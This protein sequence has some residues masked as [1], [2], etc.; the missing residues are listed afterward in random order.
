MH[1]QTSEAFGSLVVGKFDAEI[2]RRDVPD[3]GGII[4]AEA[5]DSAPDVGCKFAVVD[6]K[7]V[8]AAAAS[9]EVRS[10]AAVQNVGS[11]TDRN[12][13]IATA[14]MNEPVGRIGRDVQVVR[15]DIYIFVLEACCRSSICI[16]NYTYRLIGGG[17][18]R[19]D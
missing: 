12:R 4:D 16:C 8:R 19:G 10:G 9:Q 2:L 14:T 1:G 13:I 6:E 3:R 18:E 5:V 17:V 7:G 15:G 11:A